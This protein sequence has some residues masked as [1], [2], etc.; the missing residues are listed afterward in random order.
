[1]IDPTLLSE[2]VF[3]ALTDA[4][5]ANLPAQQLLEGLGYS[6]PIEAARQLALVLTQSRDFQAAERLGEALLQELADSPDPD[7]ALAGLSR[8]VS[9]LASPR[10]V[11]QLLVDDPRT[12]ADLILLFAT[13]IYVTE[14]LERNPY[15]YDTLLSEP[16]LPLA[17]RLGTAVEGFFRSY[18]TYEARLNGLRRLRH[19][20]T[21]AIIWRDITGRASFQRTVEEISDLAQAMV[22][23]SL[24]LCR[25][26]MARTTT[27]TGPRAGSFPFAVFAL[28]K[29][30]GRE[31]N[32]SSDVDLLF[33]TE[34]PDGQ[35]TLPH[36]SERLGERLMA[37]LTEA[38]EEGYL[39][40]ADLRLRPE[41]RFGPIVRTLESYR[42]Y[43]EK[44]MQPWERQ[45]LIK[46]RFVAG[47]PELGQRFFQMVE[48]LVYHH[49]ASYDF[50]EDIRATKE[51]LETKVA[52][53]GEAE[54]NVKQGRGAIRDVEFSLQFLQLT[55]GAEDPSL[56]TPS[57]LTALE[58]LWE[59]GILP[60]SDVEVLREA[61]LFLRVVE[62]R[63]QIYEDKPVRC[64]PSDPE[65]LDRLARRLGYPRGEEPRFPQDFLR[66]RDAVREIFTNLFNLHGEDAPPRQV[67]R[68]LLLSIETD[69][70]QSQLREALT[71]EG[72]RHPERSAA[73]LARMVGAGARISWSVRRSLTD[74][75][76]P[77]IHAAAQAPD[78]DGALHSLDSG[79]WH[80]ALREPK[81][82]LR[83]ESAL[84]LL[85]RLGASGSV[86]PEL[87]ERTPEARE[88]VLRLVAAPEAAEAA[89]CELRSREALRMELG[90]KLATAR[91]DTAALDAL[92][93]LKRRELA[94]I[95]VCDALEPLDTCGG[96]V[97]SN[98]AEPIAIGLSDLADACLGSALRVCAQKVSAALPALPL[99][100]MGDPMGFA[101]L[102]LGRLGGREL[103][104]SS[105][106]D[107]IC[108]CD[109]IAQ[110][111]DLHLAHERLAEALYR[112]LNEIALEGTLYEADFRLRPEGK[113]GS[114]A[115]SLGACE[116]YYRERAMTW[117][118]QALLKA[119]FV[120]GD[121]SVAER[122]FRLVEPYVFPVVVPGSVVEEVRAMKRRVERERV[123]EAQRAGHLK[124][125]SGG[126][127]DIEWTVQLLQLLHGGREPSVRRQGTLEALP[128]LL[129]ARL[130]ETEEA[131][132]LRSAYLLYVHLRNHLYLR[133]GTATDSL[134]VDPEEQEI[135][136]ALVGCASAQELNKHLEA[137]R[138]A[139]REIAQRRFW[140]S[141]QGE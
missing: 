43:Y 118:K 125:G 62:H 132:A 131:E 107:L 2:A 91:T 109:D 74:V 110:G 21:L 54:T 127:S 139:V 60:V 49:D 47:D 38:G 77:L 65:E 67:L 55:F 106:L 56:R 73:V 84:A 136:A 32:Y 11:L 29:L 103:N 81:S 97:G 24:R 141:G 98:H 70:A 140:T 133:T 50:L 94:R 120:A 92:R 53:E 113:S 69:A 90:V 78:P 48:S 17:E 102:G 130:L 28:G 9:S 124:L 105:D 100:P 23:A 108:L 52:S 3:A 99:T 8:W 115:A 116:R 88:D 128:A 40:R 27:L 89:A 31:L 10:S 96:A 134:P 36:G 114:M 5:A 126:L 104:Y 57:T 18:P 25:E 12:L 16:F 6:A 15:A 58:R 121:A 19:Q 123:P 59:A 30:G 34:A 82:P 35:D 46:L 4:R 122:F 112:S 14:V 20:E 13:S 61:Y 76:G 75:V 72:F 37:A 1:M 111:P 87:L 44:W 26:E 95:A 41:G 101:V 66:H 80:G 135:L 129:G 64:L 85:C 137:H 138:A 63:L 33:V 79:F 117:E 86:I 7:L 22:G 93:R 83:Q 71:A 45:A 68:G 51:V 119:R 39:Y 42:E